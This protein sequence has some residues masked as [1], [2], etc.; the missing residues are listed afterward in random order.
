MKKNIFYCLLCIVCLIVIILVLMKN[1]IS[2]DI[3]LREI[4]N[5]KYNENNNNKK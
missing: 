1:N 5:R 2:Y 3:K 4:I